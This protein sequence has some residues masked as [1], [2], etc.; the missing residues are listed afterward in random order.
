MFSSL[1]S[2]PMPG[3]ERTDRVG[4]GGVYVCVSMSVRI[5][6]TD[7]LRWSVC[8]S[9][10]GAE[11]I[12]LPFVPVLCALR[13]CVVFVWFAEVFRDLLWTLLSSYS[14]KSFFL[15][16]FLVFCRNSVSQRHLCQ[17]GNSDKSEPQGWFDSL[18]V[19]SFSSKKTKQKKA[20]VTWLLLK[21][22]VFFILSATFKKQPLYSLLGVGCVGRD[23]LVAMTFAS[24]Q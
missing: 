14:E 24:L 2:V 1:L 19:T 15:R 3:V 6:E 8:I 11:N 16:T 5:L 21:G 10:P 12:Y 18:E 17:R 23:R 13:V 20:C 9:P 4:G 7:T 22:F